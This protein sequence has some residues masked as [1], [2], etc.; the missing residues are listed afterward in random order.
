MGVL[1]FVI[2]AQ[3]IQTVLFIYLVFPSFIYNYPFC[4]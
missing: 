2:Y 1:I 4:P 3:Y